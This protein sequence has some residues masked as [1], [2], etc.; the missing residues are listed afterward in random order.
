[1]SFKSP[2]KFTSFLEALQTAGVETNGSRR[3][4]GGVTADDTIVVTAWTDHFTGTGFKIT[5]PET[6]HGRLKDAWELGR[7]AP[8]ARVKLIMLRESGSST[9]GELGQ[10]RGIKDAALLPGWWQVTQ[11]P[12]EE[13]GWTRAV[14]E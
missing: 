12:H 1:M 11:G 8:G 7:I 9:G 5:K 3:F 14:V 4:W 2:K 13:Q 6:R 10:R